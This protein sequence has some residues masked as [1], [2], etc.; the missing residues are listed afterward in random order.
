MMSPTLPSPDPDLLAELDQA[1]LYAHVHER[2]E[3]A[4]QLAREVHPGLP[5]PAVWFDLRGKGA[6]QAHYDRG[7]LRF[8]PVLLADNRQAFM[9][10]VIPHEMAHWLVFHLD[11]PRARPHGHEWK[12]VMRK[13]YGLPPVTTHRFDVSRASPAPYRY[14]CACKTP[15]HFSPRRHAL[16]R[17]GTDYRCRRCREWLVFEARIDA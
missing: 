16:A 17:R 6:G 9:V 14:R 11:G 10:E 8:N 7:G 12:T 4:W 2:V 13:L 15:H 1:A 5:R 3:A